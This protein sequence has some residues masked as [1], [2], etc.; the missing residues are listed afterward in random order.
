MQVGYVH[1]PSPDWGPL[2]RQPTGISR[3][4]GT[5]VWRAKKT[6]LLYDAIDVLAEQLH[7]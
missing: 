2:E 5:L 7:R 1:L 4:Q 3:I 6:M